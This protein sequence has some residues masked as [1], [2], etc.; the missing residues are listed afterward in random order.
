MGYQ[1]GKGLGANQQ[2][3]AEPVVNEM[4][5]GRAGLGAK[6]TGLEPNFEVTWDSSQE[7]VSGHL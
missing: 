6:R 7:D 2:G 1:P 4:R 5:L 3:R